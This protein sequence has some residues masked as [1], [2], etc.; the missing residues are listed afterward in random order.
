LRKRSSNQNEFRATWRQPTRASVQTASERKTCSLR[1]A[2]VDRRRAEQESNG[3]GNVTPPDCCRLVYAGLPEPLYFK[4][5]RP[6]CTR[7]DVCPFRLRCTRC[8]A[9]SS[10]RASPLS[11]STSSQP[12][13]S[14]GAQAAMPCCSPCCSLGCLYL[15]L[16]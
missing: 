7:C 12:I 1:T 15:L 10:A 4:R 6:C 3:E 13:L 8:D 2:E 14:A 11:P 9:C 5:I 16:I